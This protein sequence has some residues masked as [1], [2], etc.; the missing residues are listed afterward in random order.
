MGKRWNDMTDAEREEAKERKRVRLAEVDQHIQEGLQRMKDPSVWAEFIARGT[1]TAFSRYSFRNQLL[2]M[3]QDPTATDTDGFKRWQSRG[4]QVRKG[5]SSHITVFAPLKYREAVD[6][7]GKPTGQK[8][9]EG[10]ASKMV[11]KGVTLESV[12][13]ISQTDE[14]PGKP[15]KPAPGAEPLDL[16]K[17]RDLVTELAPEGDVEEILAAMDTAT[18]E[19]EGEYEAEAC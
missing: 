13:D 15:F 8:P 12:F 10:E 19:A 7:D 17:V 18:E 6:K 9:K 4:R 1:G 2:V 14:I 16:G 11:M 3:Q 5:G